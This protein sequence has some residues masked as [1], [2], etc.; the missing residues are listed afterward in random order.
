MSSKRLL[1]VTGSEMVRVFSKIGFEIEC[2][3]GS[4]IIMSR[5]D[6]L[7]V[8]PDHNPIAKGTERDLIKDAGLTIEEFNKHL[9][10]R[11]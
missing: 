11:K 9:K 10:G 6:E 3:R 2:K 1:P 8:I 5:G 4:H 7:L